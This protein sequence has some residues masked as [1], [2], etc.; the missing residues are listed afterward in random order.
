MPA[1]LKMENGKLKIKNDYSKKLDKYHEMMDN[2][3][4]N[5]IN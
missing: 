2:C 4:N 5:V 1:E 3:M